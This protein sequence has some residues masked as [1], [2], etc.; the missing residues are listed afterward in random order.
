MN[1]IQIWKDDNPISQS[2]YR[3]VLWQSIV[4]I[5]VGLCTYTTIGIARHW[6]IL[7]LG[8]LLFSL[9]IYLMTKFKFELFKPERIHKQTWVYIFTAAVL[10]LLVYWS[11]ALIFGQ[12]H[13][14]IDVYDDLRSLP[15][16]VSFIIFV[17]LAPFFEELIFRGFIMKGI[18]KGHVLIGYVVSSVLFG[19]MHGP[20]SLSE[21]LIYIGLGFVFGGVYLLTRRIEASMICH[22]LNNCAHILIFVFIFNH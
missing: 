8:L 17:I 14:Q 22:A 19:L 1:N 2:K 9:F 4:L 7:I 5:I 21:C 12:P 20:T 16:Y 10:S 15:L 18:F 6:G 11:I 3:H 13:N